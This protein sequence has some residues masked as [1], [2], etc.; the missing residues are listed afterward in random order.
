MS[1]LNLALI[2]AAAGIIGGVWALNWWQERSFR[3]KAEQAFEK[4][5]E[6]VLLERKPKTA[7]RVE[8]D[9]QRLEPSL[10]AAAAADMPVT[11]PLPQTETDLPPPVDATLDGGI[12]F[13]AELHLTE[14]VAARKLQVAMEDAA[15]IGKPVR[16]SGLEA[17]GEHWVMLNPGSVGTF[18]LLRAGLQL[19]DRKGPVSD[20]QLLEFIRIIRLTGE[21]IG[22]VVELP[23]RTPSLTAAA[24]LDAFCADVDVLIGLNIVSRDGTP[25][26][27]T[28]IRALCESAG[29]QLADDGLFHFRNEQGQTLFS[30]CNLGQESFSSATI[31]QMRVNAVTLLFDVPRVIGG[32]PVFDR[33][34]KLAGHLAESLDGELVDDNR[35]PLNEQ[36]L[37]AI[38]RQLIELYRRMEQRGIQPGGPTALRLFA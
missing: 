25:F 36:G 33:V 5:A 10:V 24:D 12:D 26:S 30:L 32:V 2:V 23:Q 3:R 14:P 34:A 29:M 17:D 38:R 4:P 11:V 35:R 1:D 20:A 19:A 37:S 7:A 18:S 13:I 9:T 15:S 21:D 8:A 31:R 16:W 28:K 22:A 6:D 27:A